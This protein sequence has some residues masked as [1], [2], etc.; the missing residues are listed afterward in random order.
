V[1]S[2]HPLQTFPRDFP[3]S[4]ILESAR[5]IVFGVDGSAAALVA[6][7]SLAR[8][9]E[10]TTLTVPPALRVLYHASCVVASNH[11]TGL[12]HVLSELYGAL[13]K[14][15]RKCFPVF[16]PIIMAT[17][18]NVARTGPAAALSGPV[19]RGGVETVDEHC[20]AVRRS[21]PHLFPF[22][23]TMTLETVRLARI[24]GS[25]SEAQARRMIDLLLGHLRAHSSVKEKK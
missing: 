16:E 6:A 25:V 4:A 5:G 18:R 8:H 13:G 12:M 23:A 15:P 9:L 19:A 2:F 3:P 7:R 24:K 11:L 20:R 1:F 21:A 17:L 14:D 10:G 22:F